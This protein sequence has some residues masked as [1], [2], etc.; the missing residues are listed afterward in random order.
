[1]SKKPQSRNVA[2]IVVRGLTPERHA[3]LKLAAKAKHQSMAGWLLTAVEA[4]LE[5]QARAQRA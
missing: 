4:A 1:M 5:E 3:Q 2:A